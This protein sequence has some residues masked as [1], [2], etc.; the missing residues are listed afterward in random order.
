[1]LS[2]LVIHEHDRC[3]GHC[4]GFGGRRF[5]QADGF[6]ASPKAIV[7]SRTAPAGSR[8]ERMLEFRLPITA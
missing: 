2:L 4:H 7:Y 3:H 5:P 1:M 6:G 8:R